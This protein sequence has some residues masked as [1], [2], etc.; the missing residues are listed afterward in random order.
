MKVKYI[1]TF[2]SMLVL[3]IILS[4]CQQPNET[5]DTSVEEGISILDIPDPEKSGNVK[6]FDIVAKE[7]EWDFGGNTVADV[8]TYNGTVPGEEIRV[9]EGDFVRVHLKNELNEPVTIH[10]HGVILPNKMDGV[11]G[12]TQDGV[13]PGDSF[14]YE[15]SADDPGTYWYHSHQNSAEQVDK[16][17]YGAFIVEPNNKV[18]DSEYTLILD[19]WNMGRNSSGGMMGGMM[20]GS[21]GEMDTDMLYGSYTVNGKIGQYIEPIE[22]YEGEVIR[23]RFVNAGYRKHLLRFNGEQYRVV[24]I[25][26]N[27]IYNTTYGSGPLEITPSERIDIEIKIDNTAE[28]QIESVVNNEAAEDMVINVLPKKVDDDQKETVEI[29][30][31]SENGLV[32]MDPIFEE[33]PT[34]DIEYDMFLGASMGMGMGNS[35]FTINEEVFPD[36]ESIEVEEDDII[37]AT[38]INE[39]Q[40]DHPMHLHGHYFQ[41][42]A[43]NGEKLDNPIVKDMINVEPGES[44]EIVFQADNPGAWAFH[45]HDLNHSAGGMMTLLEYQGYYSPF[46]I[47]ERENQPE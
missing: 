18:Y 7:S 46:D 39:S 11:A 27:P 44:I 13:Q 29:E 41:I 31:E 1:I 30:E 15:F 14:T 40:F 5:I 36:T 16:G 21:S 23:L 20:G 28:W 43:I 6:E 17:L 32:Y 26:G 12:V 45:C 10:F 42:I 35:T 25:D 9:Q 37:K 34:P 24:E 22:V 47:H 33:I 2:L 19:E 3:I 4:G 8:W 38:L